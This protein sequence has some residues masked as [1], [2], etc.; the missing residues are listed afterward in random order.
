MLLL[1]FFMRRVLPAPFAEFLQFNFSL[2]FALV[3]ARPVIGSLANS[4]LHFNKIWLRHV[5][6]V[7][8][9]FSYSVLNF[10]LTN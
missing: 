1:G 6:S 3:F 9:L 7:F 8:Q 10:Q 2:N 4:A 5:F